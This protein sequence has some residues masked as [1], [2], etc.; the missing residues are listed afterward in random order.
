[1]TRWDTTSEI[2]PSNFG[3]VAKRELAASAT[4][5]WT[6]AASR[7]PSSESLPRSCHPRRSSANGYVAQAPGR[8]EDHEPSSGLCVVRQTF[9]V[10]VAAQIQYLFETLW[11]KSGE[12]ESAE[13]QGLERLQKQ[14]VDRAVAQRIRRGK[15]LRLESSIAANSSSGSVQED[16]LNQTATRMNDI[17]K[18][19]AQAASMNFE[20]RT[21]PRDDFEI[22]SQERGWRT[23]SSKTGGEGGRQER[24]IAINIATAPLSS[25]INQQRSHH[26]PSIPTLL[27]RRP[28]DRRVRLIH[29]SPN[30]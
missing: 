25:G 11:R 12:N 14:A 2:G 4:W 10:G 18:Q 3:V 28:L 24:L 8:V 9:G 30:H 19:I 27:Q 16:K 20:F 7:I 23:A 6:Q 5:I 17:P 29:P 1:M 22:Q 13:V 15:H 26:H 21:Q